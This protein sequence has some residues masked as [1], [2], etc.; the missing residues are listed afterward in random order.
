MGKVSVVVGGQ[1]GSEA[2][3]AVAGR[4]ASSARNTSILGAERQVVGVR[5]GG[6]NAGHTVYG[7][8]PTNCTESEGHIDRAHPWRL[9]QV[10]VAAVT[11]RVASLL[12]AA[13]S[14]VDPIVLKDEIAQLDSA[15]YS[16]SHRLMVDRSATILTQEHIEREV[17]SD[18]TVR[19]GSTAKGIGAARSD[20]IWRTA[21]VAS[22]EA[23]G[24]FKD[25][26]L[27]YG[28][29]YL[30]GALSVGAH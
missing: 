16:V 11:N 21:K 3:G 19:L 4:L 15:G 7:Q 10:P 23:E 13:G 14:E 28:S 17:A 29:S 8:C 5:V 22:D 1:F 26:S 20:R 9:R 30:T 24:E 6:P 2:K 27:V 25:I 12:I 18:L